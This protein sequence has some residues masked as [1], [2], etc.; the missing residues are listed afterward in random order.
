MW[1]WWRCSWSP[2]SCR[3]GAGLWVGAGLR[4]TALQTCRL[5]QQCKLAWQTWLSPE[6]VAACLRPHPALRQID[7][8]Y[9]K[10]QT[11]C[12][13][14]D[15][16]EDY[17]NIELDSHRNALIRV[18]GPAGSGAFAA[19]HAGCACPLLGVPPAPPSTAA[20]VLPPA[21]GPGADLLHCLSG[22]HHRHHR[23]VCHEHHAAA[24]QGACRC[25]RAAAAALALACRQPPA[26]EP[27]VCPALPLLC[28][29]SAAAAVSQEGQAPYS[30]FL[31][32]SISTGVGAICVFA[33]VMAYCRWQRLI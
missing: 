29:S 1:R 19:W 6:R 15:D 8:T 21:A 32:V 5:C 30:W 28:V 26:C 23:P 11:L 12:E 33:G 13:Y 31:A 17:I 14:I 18:G 7:N 4:R 2:T 9:N 3:R 25:A 22:P 20:I 27:A 16:T 10:L 24:G